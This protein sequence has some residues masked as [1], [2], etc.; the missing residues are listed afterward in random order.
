MNEIQK[1]ETETNWE[2]CLRVA[3]ETP[4]ETLLSLILISLKENC[5]RSRSKTFQGQLSKLL[6]HGNGV[7]K[8]IELKYTGSIDY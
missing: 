5:K 4:A 6:H 3:E 8:A 7:R 2:Y 1:R